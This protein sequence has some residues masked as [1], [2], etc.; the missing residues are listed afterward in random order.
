MAFTAWVHSREKKN[1]LLKKKA[2]LHKKVYALIDI[3]LERCFSLYFII[4]N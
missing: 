2:K 3:K 4:E 1:R